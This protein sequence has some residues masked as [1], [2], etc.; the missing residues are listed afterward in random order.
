MLDDLQDPSS[1]HS[2]FAES[3]INVLIAVDD[4]S[5]AA[6]LHCTGHVRFNLHRA[7]STIFE[8]RP[9]NIVCFVL[10]SVVAQFVC[11]LAREKSASKLTA[12]NP[13]FHFGQ[14]SVCVGGQKEKPI[15]D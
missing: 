3:S 5:A 12:G 2:G 14:R 10:S 11:R 1:S 4:T 6:L 8:S 15:S 9:C 13:S 7:S